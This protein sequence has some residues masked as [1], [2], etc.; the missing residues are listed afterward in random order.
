MPA[1]RPASLAP[2]ST[3]PSLAS[4][5]LLDECREVVRKSRLAGEEARKPCT[6]LDGAFAGKPAP[7]G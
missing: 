4:Q 1:K 3:A 2:T 6:A 7:A 5:H